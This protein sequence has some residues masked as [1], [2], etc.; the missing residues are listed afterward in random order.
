MAYKAVIF[1]LDGT[2][3]NTLDDLGNA[4]NRVL[5]ERGF[6]AHAIDEYRSFIGNGVEKLINRALPE[7]NRNEDTVRACL[8]AFREDY[9]KNWNVNTRPY[10]GIPELLDA[11]KERGLKVAVLSNKPDDTTNLCV[12]ELLPKWRFDVVLGHRDGT[13]HKPDPA[14][15]LEIAQRLDIPPAEFLYLGD[16][17]V[18]MET[19]IA[20][21]MFPVGVLWGFREADELEESGAQALISHPLEVLE[22][23]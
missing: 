5:A 21:R 17:G 23:L 12:A 13:P 1:D 19:A 15:A 8:E 9:H 18:D 2:L 14:G 6:S 22:V 3:L 10:E 20:A 7:Q 16:S 4:V 11:L